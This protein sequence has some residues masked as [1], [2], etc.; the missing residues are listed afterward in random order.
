MDQKKFIIPILS[1]TAVVFMMGVVL[2]GL[3]R[4][5][6]C[7]CGKVRFWSSDINGNE[8]SQQFFD[9]YSLTHVT[10]GV[11]FY[12]IAS[13]VFP[14]LQ[15]VWRVFFA[16]LLES[17]WEIFENTDFVINRYRDATAAGGYYG[18]SIFNSM[19]DIVSSIIGVLIALKFSKRLAIAFVIIAIEVFLVFWIKDGLFLNILMLFYPIDF[20]KTWQLGG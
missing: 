7:E 3:G 1:I 19:G 5:F 6:F 17:G 15:P 10:H 13:G 20:I 8:N 11:V 2:F 4:N 9:P 12:Y 18:D 16:I 14:G